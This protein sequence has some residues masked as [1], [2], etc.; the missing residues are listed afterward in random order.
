VKQ[1]LG[2]KAESATNIRSEL[3]VLSWSSILTFR[4]IVA[5]L[6]QEERGCHGTI[7]LVPEPSSSSSPDCFFPCATVQGVKK[8]VSES[9]LARTNG[10]RQPRGYLRLNHKGAAC[11]GDGYRPGV[12]RD[13][14][15]WRPRRQ[16]GPRSGVISTCTALPVLEGEE[17]KGG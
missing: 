7:L 6:Y 10:G 16:F 15:S 17:R 4:A 9:D 14:V 3:P 2:R 11:P 8:L 1:R 13:D 12:W 5:V